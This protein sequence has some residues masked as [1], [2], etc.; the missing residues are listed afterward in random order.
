MFISH[1]VTPLASNSDKATNEDPQIIKLA[2]LI[3]ILAD[4]ETPV[5]DKFGCLRLAL[6]HETVT[7]EDAVYLWANLSELMDFM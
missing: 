2:K 3:L 6:L 1:D 7:Q 4:K 5:E